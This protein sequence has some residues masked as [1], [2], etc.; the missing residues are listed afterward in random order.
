[1]INKLIKNILVE[2][3][4]SDSS[5]TAAKYS[6][7]LTKSIKA[8]LYTLYVID[9]TVLNELSLLKIVIEDELIDYKNRLE[10]NGDM[11]LSHVENIAHENHIKIIKLL[12]EGCLT[13]KLFEACDMYNIDLIILGYW[14][15]SMQ[16]NNLTTR[17]YEDILTESKKP[18]IVVK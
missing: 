8:D 11:I 4:G 7:E 5:M 15:N 2:V 1:M 6:I 16:R 9:T 13:S 10:I 14:K 18:V 17:F 3:N 12:K